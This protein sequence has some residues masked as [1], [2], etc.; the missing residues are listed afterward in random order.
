MFIGNMREWKGCGHVKLAERQSHKKEV[1]KLKTKTYIFSDNTDYKS[2]A[3]Y[4]SKTALIRIIKRMSNINQWGNLYAY[5][6]SD[7]EGN[8][9]EITTTKK[10]QPNGFTEKW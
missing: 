10:G 4:L 7:L 5:H 9:Y 6:I 8:C 1:R 3:T 2:P